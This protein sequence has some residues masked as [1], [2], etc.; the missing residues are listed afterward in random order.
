MKQ[1]IVAAAL[2][3]TTMSAVADE[4]DIKHFILKNGISLYV[5]SDHR[6][7]L[8]WFQIWYNVGSADETNGITGI[9]HA[10][11]HMMFKGTQK[12]TDGSIAKIVSDNGGEQNAFTS[13]DYTCYWQ[14]FPTDKIELSFDIESDR[15]QNLI[16]RDDDFDKEKQVILEERKMRVDNNP[17]ML[18]YEQFAAA[19]F[20]AAPYQEPVIG[21]QR[22]I[23]N[24]TV[25]DLRKWYDSWYKPANATIVIA[26]DVNPQEMLGLA[27]KY[28][29]NIKPGVL[30]KRVDL[31]KV[32]QFGKKTLTVNAPAQNNSFI[33]GFSA[34]SI[35]EAEDKS[36]IYAL[37]LLNTL[38]SGG[39]NSILTRKLQREK[40]V[41]LEIS[42]YYSPFAKHDG[43]ILFSAIPSAGIS[44]VE[45]EN[46]LWQELQNVINEPI[47][48]EKIA[49]AKTQIIM[50][51]R[52]EKEQALDR[53]YNVGSISSI[54]LSMHD[55]EIFIQQLQQVTAAQIQQVAKK[56]FNINHATISYLEPIK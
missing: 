12:Y 26:G 40:Q 39:E 15:M 20:L 29:S 34:P 28:F 37:T 8:A 13:R 4:Q 5:I 24:L 36:D 56:Y 3:L 51:E 41:A 49:I 33:L 19:M 2:L 16:L 47:A 6:T 52:Y 7:P 1:Y 25:T 53:A 50:A 9:S 46:F 10:L 45:L 44:S 31:K 27:N 38:L 55:Y 43:A 22:D 54:G 21:W 14:R 42:S 18:N 23:E 32:P 30:A 11:E 48:A 35:R 17:D